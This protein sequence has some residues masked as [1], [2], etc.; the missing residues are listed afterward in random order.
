MDWSERIDNKKYFVGTLVALSFASFAGRMSLFDALFLVGIIIAT[1]LNQW[2]MFVVLGKLLRSMMEQ[3]SKPSRYQQLVLWGQIGLKFSV[4]GA[5]FYFLIGY[6]RHLAAFGLILY[7]FQ[8]IIL[9]LSIK[10][11]GA[12]LKKGS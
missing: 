4:L 8:L 2:L 10:N 7:T 11:I 9:V 3:Q 1:V 5:M 12:F 6:A